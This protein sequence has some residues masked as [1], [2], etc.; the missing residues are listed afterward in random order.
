MMER[1]LKWMAGCVFAHRQ[2][3]IE[4]LE[5]AGTMRTNDG[6]DHNCFY[7]FSL[8]LSKIIYGFLFLSSFLRCSLVPFSVC[9][10]L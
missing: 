10:Y 6:E 4:V 8:S 9:F 2:K 3:K 1:E 7:P 5:S